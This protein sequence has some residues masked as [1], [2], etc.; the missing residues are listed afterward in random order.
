MRVRPD[1]SPEDIQKLMSTVSKVNN[2]DCSS[3]HPAGEDEGGIKARMPTEQELRDYMSQCQEEL[4]SLERMEGAEDDEEEEEVARRNK[5]AAQYF[6][7]QHY[8]S[9]IQEEGEESELNTPASSRPASMARA[10]SPNFL[11]VPLRHVFKASS[12]EDHHQGRRKRDSSDSQLS[13][14]SMA[15]V[16]SILSAE[17]EEATSEDA[18]SSGVHS[19]PG[20]KRESKSL[21][22]ILENV[23][24]P[25]PPPPPPTSTITQ[26]PP[27]STNS[28]DC[29]YP[30]SSSFSSEKEG[31]ETTTEDAESTT[32]TTTDATSHRYV[33]TVP[34]PMTP[35]WIR[36]SPSSSQ[37]PPPA[38]T[39]LCDDDGKRSDGSGTIGVLSPP[40]PQPVVPTSCLPP[41]ES[42]TTSASEATMADSRC[43]SVN[44]AVRDLPRDEDSMPDIVMDVTKNVG[45]TPGEEGEVNKRKIVESQKKDKSSAGGNN[46]FATI[47]KK[48]KSS[49]V[50]RGQNLKNLNV[51]APNANDVM[52]QPPPPPSKVSQ[53]FKSLGRRRSSDENGATK[54][55]GSSRRSSLA[56]LTDKLVERMSSSSR[57]SN[58]DGDQP[59]SSGND[60]ATGPA[61]TI[62]NTMRQGK[63]ASKGKKTDK[64]KARPDSSHGERRN[65]RQPKEIIK[66]T[67]TSPPP[68]PMPEP[69]PYRLQVRDEGSEESGSPAEFSEGRSDH[70]QPTTL[71]TETAAFDEEVR[72]AHDN[73]RRRSELRA[74]S[75]SKKLGVKVLPAE[76]NGLKAIGTAV[77]SEEKKEESAEKGGRGDTVEDII[78]EC[79]D[80]VSMAEEDEEGEKEEENKRGDGANRPYPIQKS[81][82]RKTPPP[83]LPKPTLLP[84]T[85]RSLNGMAPPHPQ[86]RHRQQ[87][88]QTYQ[89]PLRQHQYQQRQQLNG[90]SNHPKTS[91]SQQ[92]KGYGQPQQGWQRDRSMD[93]ERSTERPGGASL[94]RGSFYENKDNSPLPDQHPTTIEDLGTHIEIFPANNKVEVRCS[95]YPTTK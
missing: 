5:S 29:C 3:H 35:V 20:V 27:P 25:P 69:P 86:V 16:N 89:Q 46:A 68:Q 4:V 79:E 17:E 60:A 82:P 9:I 73:P 81:P 90:N 8:L 7:R 58:H 38:L 71:E 43:S 48:I 61:A 85:L 55:P 10:A 75:V 92:E 54:P 57:L 47:K 88:H 77:K 23:P 32:T 49:R 24:P 13:V 94:L 53:F 78:A 66:L 74:K 34:P 64:E 12:R 14:D 51:K 37:Q 15:S 6:Y 76:A 11:K 56:S 91:P 93:P 50:G 19:F 21:S 45:E 41:L 72:S 18:T 1:L 67:D 44:E 63:D 84:W 33:V 83:T 2:S 80:Y 39:T 59:A 22:Q 52:Q 30:A 28:E 31:K 87:Q 26:S 95:T 40:P 42:S 65:Q 70:R 62:P 36:Q